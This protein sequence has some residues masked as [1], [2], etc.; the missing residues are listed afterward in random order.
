MAGE[1]IYFD[2]A[3]TTAPAWEPLGPL[4]GGKPVTREV[5]TGELELADIWIVG[6][7]AKGATFVGG[8]LFCDDLD[9]NATP[10]VV[11]DV[12]VGS[13]TFKA[14]LTTAQAG[15]STVVLGDP[16]TATVESDI[17]IK[18]A[19]APATAQAGTVSFVPLIV[20]S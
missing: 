9:S 5:A 20:G 18:V 12:L 10:A 6:R 11:L 14:G 3:E 8:L 17:K 19:T 7:L 16:I 1:T 13:T 4:M 2:G 15:G